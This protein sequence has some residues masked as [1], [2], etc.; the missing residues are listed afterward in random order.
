[1]PELNGTEAEF[2][3]RYGRAHLLAFPD[4]LEAAETV[5]SWLLTAP[6]AHPLWAQYHLGTVRLRDLEGWPPPRRQF[7]GATHEL[8]V[9]ALNPEY[10]PYTAENMRRFWDGEMAGRMPY[11]TPVNIA[12][13]IEASDEEARML[14]LY[15]AWGVTAGAVWPE[16]ADAPQ[17]IR[18]EW[19]S[20]LVKT[21]AHIRGEVH[22]S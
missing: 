13:Q 22:A 5:C 19:D 20:V 21:L 18:A 8:T 11:L 4:T 15:S 17:R 1:M 10:G 2:K 9:V 12:H 14:A 3:G 16:T 6:H 7:P